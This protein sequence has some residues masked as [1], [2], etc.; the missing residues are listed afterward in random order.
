MLGMSGAGAL[1]WAKKRGLAPTTKGFAFYPGRRE[2]VQRM[3]A[4]GRSWSDVGVAL[5][6]SAQAVFCWSVR[7]GMHAKRKP[8]NGT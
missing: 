4:E 6:I 2:T 8:K 5:G 3:R 7:H 1:L